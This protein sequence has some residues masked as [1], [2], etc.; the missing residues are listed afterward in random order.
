M[1]GRW[2]VR[3]ARSIS[4]SK[5]LTRTVAGL[6]LLFALSRLVIVEFYQPRGTDVTIYHRWFAQVEQ[7]QTPYRTLP[8]EYP[9]VAWWLMQVPDTVDWPTYWQRFRR[10]ML[11]I[12]TAGFACFLA[13]A[14]RRNPQLAPYAGA[15]YIAATSALAPV[16][17]DRLD[18]GLILCLMF[19]AYAWLRGSAAP[20]GR[21][22][23]LTIAYASIGAGIAFK[24]M[25][26]FVAPLLLLSE[27]TTRQSLGAIAAR[28]GALAA[29]LVVPFAVQYPS[30]GPGTL[31]FLEY[32]GARGLELESLPANLLWLL[33]LAGLPA[34][35]EFRFTSFELDSPV[36]AAVARLSS[37]LMVGLLLAL[38]WRAIRLGREYTRERAYLFGCV[39]LPLVLLATKVL[40]PQY[41][42]FVAPLMLLAGAEVLPARRSFVVFAAL[43]V[44]VS[45]LTTAVYPFGFGGLRVFR[46]DVWTILTVRNALFAGLVG[47]L[48]VR[49][50]ARGAAPPAAVTP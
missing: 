9:P 12:E 37:A 49:L 27:L 4:S 38:V 33:S 22:P 16:L 20:H 2:R 15:A 40:S 30:G 7:G 36:S 1:E 10:T 18:A 21:S 13:V 43:V 24:L 45:L 34:S 6:V 14:Y 48:F 47:W 35:I 3:G 26:L 17:F 42:V 31:A 8:I 19:S 28:A 41:F 25:P 44:L 23:W 29:G 50:P 32:H 46:P 5:R 11:A 39:S